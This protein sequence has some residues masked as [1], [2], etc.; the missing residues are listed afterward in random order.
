MAA[1]E[2]HVGNAALFKL[3]EQAVLSFDDEND[4]ARW[5]KAR[6]AAVR[7][8][9]L[10]SHRWHFALRRAALTAVTTAPAFGYVRAFPLP[11]DCLQLVQVGEIDMAVGMADLRG[12]GGGGF[13]LEGRQILTNAAAPLNIRYVC[14]AADPSDWDALFD[15]A[16]ACRLAFDL[17]EKLTQSGTKKETAWG[18]YQTALREARRVNAIE[19]PVQTLGDDS[20]VLGR[21]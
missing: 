16:L 14:R 9:T 17:A 3:G 1:S 13:S 10:R 4:R 6:F 11:T 19:I 2:T 12:A 7:D 20:W 15:E 8:A 21:Q 5:L 18:E